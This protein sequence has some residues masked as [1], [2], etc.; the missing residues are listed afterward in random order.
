MTVRH[1][2]LIMILLYQANTG[3]DK[4]EYRGRY[5]ITMTWSWY[6]RLTLALTMMNIGGATA[7]LWPDTDI[8]PG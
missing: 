3:I 8:I 5:N 1:S 6:T 4:E 2:S 7:S